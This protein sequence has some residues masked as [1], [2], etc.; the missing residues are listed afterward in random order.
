VTSRYLLWP[1]ANITVLVIHLSGQAKLN[2]LVQH[3]TCFTV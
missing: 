1:L 3:I 2:I